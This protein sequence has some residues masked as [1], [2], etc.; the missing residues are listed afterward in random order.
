MEDRLQKFARVVEAGSITKAAQE[1][2]ISQPALSTAIH[3]L[4]REL[5]TQLI[6]HTGRTIEI[7][8]AGREAYKTANAIR[9]KLQDMQQ[10]LVETSHQKPL[11]RIGMIDSLAEL[12][13]INGDLLEKLDAFSRTSLTINNSA[14]LTRGVT[15]GKLD[16]VLIAGEIRP[17]NSLLATPVGNEPLV[18]VSGITELDITK[19]QLQQGRIANF[20]AYNPTSKTYKLIRDRLTMLGLQPQTTFHSTSP[21]VI[22]RLVLASRGTAA[23]PFQMVFEH[24]RSGSLVQLIPQSINRPITA[25]IADD[26]QLSKSIGLCIEQARR[27]LMQLNQIAAASKLIN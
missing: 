9:T 24:L 4:E 7:T 6:K 25:V 17:T 14:V 21:E 22:L 11:V 23:L 18:L 15:E 10:R 5:K 12:L 19:Q 8:P 13:C 27:S 1:L 20:L 26:R 2:H 16:I 3:K